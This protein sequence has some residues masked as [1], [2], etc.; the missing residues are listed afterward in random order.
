MNP[1]QISVPDNAGSITAPGGRPPQQAQQFVQDMLGNIQATSALNPVG[2]EIN[3][4]F[5]L[6]ARQDYTTIEF[7]PSFQGESAAY[8]S[9]ATWEMLDADTLHF[10]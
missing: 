6:G 5:E 8:L 7:G 10:L 2:P 3:E 9:P 4:A 1:I